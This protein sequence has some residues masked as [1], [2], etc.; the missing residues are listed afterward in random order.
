MSSDK[1][2][3]SISY[4]TSINTTRFVKQDVGDVKLGIQRTK[5]D[6][7]CPMKIMLLTCLNY[8]VCFNTRFFVC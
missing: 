4:I 3:V 7:L 6:H 8:V 5:Y 1:I 2:H